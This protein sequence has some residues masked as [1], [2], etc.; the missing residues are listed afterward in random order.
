MRAHT[1]HFPT[2]NA[3]AYAEPFANN[4]AGAGGGL[5]DA[6]ATSISAPPSETMSHILPPGLSYSTGL[7]PQLEQFGDKDDFA[8]FADGTDTVNI[9]V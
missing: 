4:G 9:L 7:T 2:T 5:N 8:F 3:A 1:M 6:S